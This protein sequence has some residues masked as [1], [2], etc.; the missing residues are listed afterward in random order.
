MENNI[1]T[2]VNLKFGELS[3]LELDSIKTFIYML[4]RSDDQIDDTNS[5]IDHFQKQLDEN[6]KLLHFFA[7]SDFTEEELMEKAEFYGLLMNVMPYCYKN[8]IEYSLHKWAYENR[9]KKREGN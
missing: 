2:K 9:N 7:Q 8:I 1:E 6:M 4:S 3:N 5:M